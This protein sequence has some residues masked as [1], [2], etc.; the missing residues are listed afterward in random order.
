MERF[1][2]KTVS[3]GPLSAPSTRAVEAPGC[4]RLP[5]PLG[6]LCQH[7]GRV[8][9][10]CGRSLG[11][12]PDYQLAY[13]DGSRQVSRRLERSQLL[14]LEAHPISDHR[15]PEGLR[16]LLLARTVPAGA[17]PVADTVPFRG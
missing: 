5:L 17:T 7:D 6:A 12:V 9:Y 11:T 10:V 16:S 14:L 13:A 2:D 8:G 15:V 4:E 3:L 1:E